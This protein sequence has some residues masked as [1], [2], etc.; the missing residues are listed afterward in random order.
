M[1]RARPALR[2]RFLRRRQRRGQIGTLALHQRLLHDADVAPPDEPA[3]IDSLLQVFVV[4]GVTYSGANATDAGVSESMRLLSMDVYVMK[5]VVGGDAVPTLSQP[6]CP[7]NLT[8]ANGTAGC[9]SA[10]QA[11]RTLSSLPTIAP[12]LNA[13]G[14]APVGAARGASA[15]H[16]G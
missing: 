16:Y 3:S 6:A 13:T 8:H 11:P 14:R 1:A 10:A 4:G 9:V 7:T 15:A 12:V 2:S 5:L